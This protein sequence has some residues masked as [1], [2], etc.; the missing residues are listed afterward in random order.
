MKDWIVFLSGQKS[1]LKKQ[2][3]LLECPQPLELAQAS[4]RFVTV[5]ITVICNIFVYYIIFIYFFTKET[6]VFFN[7]LDSVVSTQTLPL[8]CPRISLS[9]FLIILATTHCIAP[10]MMNDHSAGS[11]NGFS[12]RPHEC[13]TFNTSPERF[14]TVIKV[15]FSHILPQKSLLAISPD[16]QQKQKPLWFCWH[17]KWVAR[18]VFYFYRGGH[19]QLG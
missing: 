14:I 3:F 18:L 16:P 12:L 6:T 17:Q 5:L 10:L 7:I 4:F 19:H 13:H 9:M 11:Q 2:L 8:W 15:L 1:L